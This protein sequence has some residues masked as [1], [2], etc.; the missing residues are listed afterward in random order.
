MHV[1]KYHAIWGC[2]IAYRP[3]V[4]WIPAC[5]T[6]TQPRLKEVIT[7]K[8]KKASAALGLLSC[9][10][11]LVHMGYS[12]FAYL[13]FYYNPTLKMITALPF[14]LFVCAH[15]ICGMCSVFLQ[16]DGTR[17]D[18]YS[19]PNLRTILQRVSAAF[20]FPLLIVHL[21]TFDLLSGASSSGNW[22]L[23]GF[24]V[25]LQVLFFAVVVVHTATSFSKGLITLG[26]LAD[27]NAQ[28]MLDRIVYA[29]CAAAFAIATFAVLQGELAMFLAK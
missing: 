18:V 26:F 1:S 15:A 21:R 3:S 22:T 20:I 23:L 24:I 12:A 29:L 25:L 27:R 13:T 5:D 8:L 10:S 7:T 16:G 28:K 14:M 4:V 11:L 17:L 6:A 9:L 2:I 19:K